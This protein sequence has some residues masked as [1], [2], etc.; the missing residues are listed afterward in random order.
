MFPSIGEGDDMVI[1]GQEG[2]PDWER[3]YAAYSLRAFK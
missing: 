2:S 1:G 3:T